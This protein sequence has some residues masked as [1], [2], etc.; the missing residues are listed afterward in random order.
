MNAAPTVV[1][2]D[3]ELTLHIDRHTFRTR[4]GICQSS[5]ILRIRRGLEP[6]Q[7]TFL[8]ASPGRYDHVDRR[9]RR[10]LLGDGDN[11]RY[12]RIAALRPKRGDA[13]RDRDAHPG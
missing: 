8:V 13:G 4:G 6:G 3:D 2:R 1:Q 11:G 12:G 5:H 9:G 10:F 7:G